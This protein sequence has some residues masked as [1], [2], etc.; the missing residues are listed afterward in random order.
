MS[1]DAALRKSKS[2]GD[3]PQPSSASPTQTASDADHPLTATSDPNVE[4]HAGPSRLG[5]SVSPLPT[6]SLPVPTLAPIRQ[7]PRSPMPTPSSTV[8][9]PPPAPPPR[10]VPQTRYGRIMAFLGFGR[11]ADPVRR[12]NMWLVWNFTWGTSQVTFIDELSS[13]RYSYPTRPWS[14]SSFS[15][16]LLN[17]KAKPSQASTNGTLVNGLLG[18]G[19]VFGSPEYSWPWG[20]RFGSGGGNRLCERIS[21]HRLCNYV[22]TMSRASRPDLESG[23]S[24]GAATPSVS[25]PTLGSLQSTHNHNANTNDVN[26]PTLP[27]TNLYKRCVFNLPGGLS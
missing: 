24:S 22:L 1:S 8:P 20:S 15:S 7:S 26:S 2:A 5:T 13:Y 10:R 16:Y 6:P 23:N 17:L 11:N 12:S 3:L 25:R 14:S 19:L 21:H 18:L 27:Y 9:Q 4:R